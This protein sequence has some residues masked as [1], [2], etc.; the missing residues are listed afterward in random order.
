MISCVCFTF[1]NT[2]SKESFAAFDSAILC[3]MTTLLIGHNFVLFSDTLDIFLY[4]NQAYVI[5]LLEIVR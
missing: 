3:S 4:L 5:C 2:D 1:F